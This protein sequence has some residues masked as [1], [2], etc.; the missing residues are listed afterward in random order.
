MSSPSPDAHDP[1]FEDREP[2]LPPVTPA[3]WPLW[4]FIAALLGGA[5]YLAWSMLRATDPRA[6]LVAIELDG[7]WFE[8]SMAAAELADA[9][10]GG[11]EALGFEPVRPGDPVV[12]TTL[13]GSEG[14]LAAAA[15]SL[16]AGFVVT[17]R[18]GVETIEHPVRDGYFELRAKGTVEVFHVDDDE[19]DRRR[20]G[21][22]RGWA[23]APERER[24]LRLLADG[25]ISRLAL[26]ETLPLLLEHPVLAELLQGD[27]RTVSALNE[28]SK[29]VGERHRALSTAEKAYEGY[30]RRRQ[31]Y[32]KGPVEVTY[33]GSTADD[34]ALCGAGAA[35]VC[36][37]TESTRPYFSPR[38]RKLR[39]LEELE[40]VEWRPA[41][42]DPQVLWAGYNVPGYPRVAPDGAS[43]AFVEDIF[44][45]AK[46]PTL[47]AGGEAKRLLVDP[48]R[49][50][51]QAQPAPGAARVA[52]FA[53]PERR[54]PR[55][56]LV[57]DTAGEVVLD[58]PPTGGSYDRFTWLDADHLVLV[59]TPPAAAGD[60][61]DE[62]PADEVD[63]AIEP[64]V[65]TAAQTVWKVPVDGAPPTALYVAQPGESLQWM[66]RSN[67]GHTLAFERRYA[68][69]AADGDTPDGEQEAQ[70]GPG[71]AILDLKADPPALTAWGIER[72]VEAPQFS[73][74]GRWLTFEYH[75]PGS[76]DEEIAVI[77]L[78]AA[79][80]AAS[81]KVLTDN[82][83]R[84][85]Y[86]VFSADGKRIYFEQ[87]G[88]DPNNRRRGVSLIA[89]VPAP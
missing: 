65:A 1:L 80:P 62:A 42:G 23:G 9:V 38:R 43:I 64:F 2:S 18:I 31:M 32:E 30:A 69:P 68:A 41:N 34:D 16:G 29:F 48:E 88:E 25:S 17:G 60:D 21:D 35:G 74:D 4:L 28:A 44:G 20:S 57:L 49:Y 37:K 26:G 3:R 45:W 59:Q 63:P 87:L 77:D 13:E 73:P 22:L 51:T 78:Q 7:H 76:R 86:P 47:I 67:D 6:V 58:L 36:V 79:D 54:G 84:D 19:G 70:P 12:L 24:A 71:L 52:L 50:Y 75:P 40:T 82:R 72:R 89:S 55:S 11:L 39:M 46:A 56:V 66:R 61:T 10:N 53:Q 85:R 27:A 8:G 81:L 83:E 5:G 33:H 14:D 15:R